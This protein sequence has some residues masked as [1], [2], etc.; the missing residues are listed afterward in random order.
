MNSH[1]ESSKTKQKKALWPHEQSIGFNKSNLVLKAKP[2]T[3]LKVELK[4]RNSILFTCFLV[5]HVDR[6]IPLWTFKWLDISLFGYEYA[7]QWN[8]LWLLLQM[9]CKHC[10][11]Q[12]AAH[13][14]VYGH[15]GHDRKEP[16]SLASYLPPLVHAFLQNVKLRLKWKV[17]WKCCPSWVLWILNN[18]SC[19]RWSIGK[20]KVN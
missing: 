19:C 15:T 11:C 14:A 1:C 9:N 16:H 5:M 3:S 4:M 12:V 2:T 8:S 17:P 18:S 10:G 13:G 7:D 20:M 6:Y